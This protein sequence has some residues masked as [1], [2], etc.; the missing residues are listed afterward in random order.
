MKF[1]WDN[2]ADIEILA[3]YEVSS[4]QVAFPFENVLNLSRRSKVWRSNGFWNIVAGVN[5]TFIFR[6]SNGGSDRVAVVT[7]GEYN[8]TAS[9]LVAL[10]TAMEAVG[11][12]NYTLTYTTQKKIQIASDGAYF[13]LRNAD[14]SST[15]A[16]VLGFD[17]ASNISYATTYI[18]DEIRINSGEGEWFLFDLGISSFPNAFSLISKRNEPMPFSPG[19][20]FKLK[21]NHTNS[22]L[23]WATPVYSATLSYDPECIFQS[24]DDN[25]NFSNTGLRYW[26]V[27]IIDQ[28]VKGYDELG[29]CFLGRY[30]SPSRCPQFPFISDFVD[31]ST[32]VTSEGGQSFSDVLPQTQT[33]TVEF[34]FLT[35]DDIQSIRNYFEIFG[36]HK[37]FFIEYD[38]KNYFSTGL[39][40]QI[41]YVKFLDEPKYS[42]DYPNLFS[43]N[44]QFKEEL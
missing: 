36:K 33:Y 18:A 6:D 21:G 16:D 42:L 19:T 23:G 17:T 22:P 14:V 41:K 2:Y 26:R 5:D 3:N 7:A 25:L 37:P 13:E 9:F 38:H 43:V 32:I 4:E 10:D 27:D 30:F 11:S 34:K 20:L 28:N 44:M 35:K 29:A 12:Q 8:S 15:L 24:V 31:S 40:R 39:N 1:Y